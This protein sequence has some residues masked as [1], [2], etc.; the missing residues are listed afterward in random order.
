[1]KSDGFFITTIKIPKTFKVM[2][3]IDFKIKN[4]QG[5]EKV[6]SLRVGK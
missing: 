5:L 2:K 6:V 3:G 1:M 4:N